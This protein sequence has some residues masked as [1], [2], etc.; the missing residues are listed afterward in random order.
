MH[1]L[2][3]VFCFAVLLSYPVFGQSTVMI[4]SNENEAVGEIVHYEDIFG[5]MFWGKLQNDR[6]IDAP[7]PITFTYTDGQTRRNVLVMPNDTIVL[8]RRK[9]GGHLEVMNKDSIYN[10]L[11]LLTKEPGLSTEYHPGFDIHKTEDSDFKLIISTLDSCH[12]KR[13]EVVSKFTKSDSAYKYTLEKELDYYRIVDLLRPYISENTN[14]LNI[15]KWY[16]DT[17]RIIKDTVTDK[18]SL[19]MGGKEYRTAIVAL[20]SFL[21]RDSLRGDDPANKFYTEFSSA[22]HNFNGIQ[23]SYLMAWLLQK[24]KWLNLPDFQ[25]YLNRF[26]AICKDRNLLA[27]VM[28]KVDNNNFEYPN[29]ILKSKLKKPDNTYSSWESV[30][31]KHKG[32]VVMVTFWAS[33]CGPCYYYLPYLKKIKTQ[34]GLSGLDII[35][36]SIDE[37]EK[38]W[39]SGLKLYN[40]R[41]GSSEHYL[42]RKSKS[43]LS[44]FLMTSRLTETVP[45]VIP[46]YVLLDSTGKI[47]VSRMPSADDE[48][49]HRILQVYIPEEPIDSITIGKLE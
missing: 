30:L 12:W 6:I 26:Y 24:Y 4:Y 31:N 3:K 36:I 43:S 7:F 23:Q 16:Q 21:C 33:W 1:L 32:K 34:Y 37:D 20:N 48:Q 46:N 25:E 42:T 44:Q 18:D 49:I 19:W 47:I 13:K 22:L 5:N 14:I 38:K 29:Q 10:A 27:Y 41:F 28:D 17:I 8:G 9:T 40:D 39:K 2:Y 45:L 11:V 15:P 35:S